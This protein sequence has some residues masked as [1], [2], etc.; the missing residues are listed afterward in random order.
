MEHG[1][2]VAGDGGD[3]GPSGRERQYHWYCLELP[4]HNDDKNLTD[5]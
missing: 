1:K 3:S 2:V 4:A 5:F